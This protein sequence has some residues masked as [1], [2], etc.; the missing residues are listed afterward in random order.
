[1]FT[2]AQVQKM[3]KGFHPSITGRSENATV[4]KGSLTGNRKQRREELSNE[5]SIKFKN[6]PKMQV[7]GNSRFMHFVQTINQIDGSVKKI[8]HSILIKK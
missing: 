4:G 2:K 1:M 5:G 7:I 8:E 6:R 3:E